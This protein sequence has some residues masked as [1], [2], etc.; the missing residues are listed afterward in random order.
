MAERLCSTFCTVD[1]NYWQTQSNARASL[2]QQS[3]L[4]YTPSH[5]W[6][7]TNTN[8]V[9]FNTSSGHKLMGMFTYMKLQKWG[10]WQTLAC[11][12]ALVKCTV[13]IQVTFDVT[14]EAKI[15]G[16]PA[17]R[18]EWTKVFNIYPAGLT[19]KL[20]VTVHLD[21]ECLCET[22]HNKVWNLFVTVIYCITCTFTNVVLTVN[23]ELTLRN[24]SCL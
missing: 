2:R 9:R 3:Y 24:N 10:S 11:P 17:D 14:I 16:C 21:C 18:N 12:E 8:S 1:A 13:W 22:P 19:E 6:H 7:V 5:H 4:L 23:Y 15:Q 20:T